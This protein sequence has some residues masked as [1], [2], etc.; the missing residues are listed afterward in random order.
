LEAEINNGRVSAINV[1]NGGQGYILDP[2]TNMAAH[3]NINTGF[4]T[5]IVY[6]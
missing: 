4:I 3:V 6:R 2:G 5:D 1:I